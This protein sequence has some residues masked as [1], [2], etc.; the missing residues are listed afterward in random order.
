MR[1]M[2]EGPMVPLL[3]GVAE[4]RISKI[5][6]YCQKILEEVGLEGLGHKMD[7]ET[8]IKQVC[9]SQLGEIIAVEYQFG[10]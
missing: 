10:G 2:G 8:E 6:E 5:K 4:D 3:A 1:A 9:D 7:S